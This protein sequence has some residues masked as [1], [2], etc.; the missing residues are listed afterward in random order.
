MILTQ[1]S[2]QSLRKLDQR[3]EFLTIALIGMRELLHPAFDGYLISL[4]LI[5]T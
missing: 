2:K 4:N 1:S 5:S 3:F